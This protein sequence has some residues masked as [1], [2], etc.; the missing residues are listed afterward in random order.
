VG[1][2]PILPSDTDSGL[3]QST[4]ASG[5]GAR[6][7]RWMPA[8][9]MGAARLAAAFHN[10]APLQLMQSDAEMGMRQQDLSDRR[11][12]LASQLQSQDLDR[13][14]KQ[15]EISGHQS[16]AEKQAQ[17]LDTLA[18]SLKLQ[19]ENAE[20]QLVPTT[21]ANGDISYYQRHF[22]PQTND[23]D[24]TPAMVTTQETISSPDAPKVPY[25]P[26][27]LITRTKRAQLTTQNP[28][29]FKN[30]LELS[31]QI[32]LATNPQVQQAKIAVANAE[33]AA[34][35]SRDASIAR[36]SN[37]ALTNVPP[38]LV[39]A[40]SAEAQKAADDYAQSRMVS[41]NI[42]AVMDAARQGN[43]QAY[44]ILPEEGALQISTTQGVHRINL[45]EIQN[46]A[47]G[48]SLWQQLLGHAGKKLTGQSI[49]PDVLNDMGQIQQVYANGALSK[50]QN[51]L[52][53]LNQNYGSQF[54]PV[55]MGGTAPQQGT[56]SLQD[57]L[58]E[59]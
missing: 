43:V 38:H 33:G 45:A 1:V 4:A 12:L 18:K 37:A 19:H 56:I 2:P 29:I 34:R 22:N 57:F 44:Q 48:G 15:L 52:R 50:Y 32:S 42:A 27:A 40:V 21:G 25:R 36:G 53:A 17:E 16:P 59:K 9:Q 5:W 24:I 3:P 49:P 51:R 8:I 26:D 35:A 41:D 23:W 55:T 31:R 6:L 30:N 39:Q 11:A 58:N 46:Y 7:A 54:Q 10:Y 28:E 14:M 20:P 47:G 13:Q